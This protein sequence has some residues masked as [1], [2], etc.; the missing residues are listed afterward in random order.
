[1]ALLLVAVSI[2]LFN[3][4]VAAR[5]LSDISRAALSVAIWFVAFLAFHV[6]ALL[7]FNAKRRKEDAIVVG[8]VLRGVRNAMPAK[9]V[10][11][12]TYASQIRSEPT[13]NDQWRGALL[14]HDRCVVTSFSQIHDPVV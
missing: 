11:S 1:L 4:W 9:V 8:E 12:R 10:G 3:A 2:E 14:D 13:R 5:L 6:E 7:S